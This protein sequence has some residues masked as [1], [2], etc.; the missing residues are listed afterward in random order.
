ME[1]TI[2]DSTVEEVAEAIRTAGLSERA[3]AMLAAHAVAP[4][5]ALSRLSWPERW[6]ARRSTS[7]TRSLGRRAGRLPTN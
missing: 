6:A 2:D 7:P 5:R 4:N 3:I 1:R